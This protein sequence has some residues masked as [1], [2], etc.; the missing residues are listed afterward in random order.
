MT[1]KISKMYIVG[2]ITQGRGFESFSRYKG[3]FNKISIK[4]STFSRAFF[5]WGGSNRD[6]CG[7]LVHPFYTQNAPENCLPKCDVVVK[8]FRN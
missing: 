3:K 5:V 4:S 8:I 7:L 6:K 2:F 1:I